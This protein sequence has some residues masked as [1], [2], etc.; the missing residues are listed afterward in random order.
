MSATGV[1]GFDLAEGGQALLGAAGATALTVDHDGAT[2]ADAALDAELEQA[3][4]AGPLE[5]RHHLASAS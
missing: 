3:A 1:S 2:L 4:P 5:G